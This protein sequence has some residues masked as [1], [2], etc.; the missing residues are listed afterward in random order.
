LLIKFIRGIR[1]TICVI[2]V[3]K[4]L[5]ITQ[6]V[7]INDDTL[8]FFHGWIKK[9]AEKTD[10]IDVICLQKG[11]YKLPENI[12]IYSL[13][14]EKNGS[15]NSH[16]FRKFAFLLR[17]YK[18]TW[19]LLPKNDLLFVHMNH[20]YIFLLWPLLKIFRKP[21]VL[22]KASRRTNQRFLKLATLFAKRIISYSKKSFPF[23]TG[24]LASV[25]PAVDTGKFRIIDDTKRNLRE[26]LFVG[27]ISS[28]KNLEKIVDLAMELK[29]EGGGF[30]FKIVGDPGEKNKKYLFFIKR[31]IKDKG[32]ENNFKFL[33][34]VPNKQL[35]QYYN[36]ASF[37][38]DFSSIYGVNKTL[39][40]AMVCG[41]IPIT[42][43][44][45]IKPFLGCYSNDIFVQS[46]DEAKN[47]ILDL[48]RN[49]QKRE[50]LSKELSQL[51]QKNHN[52]D[53][54][55][56]KLVGVFKNVIT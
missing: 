22:F 23:K 7:D 10:S 35:P 51:I 24:K 47:K 29:K 52:L 1:V 19:K 33:G 56:N 21:A 3:M 14:K 9:L 2:R 37:F 55:T 40:E 5:I 17:L 42:N 26:I 11:D 36:Q 20:K 34:S 27:R 44:T 41:C 32:I 46:V 13:G 12:S 54:L 53:N 49:K 4:I 30:K 39:L 31:L 6:K 25:S 16:I 50:K 18:Y 43:Q 15:H 28:D 45:T 38:V 8:G 48:Y